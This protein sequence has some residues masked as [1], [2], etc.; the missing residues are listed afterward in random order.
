M[1]E[2]AIQNLPEKP[3][4]VLRANESRIGADLEELWKYREMFYFLTWRDVKV[5]YKQTALGAL[6]AL[7]QPL[8]LMLI[9]TLFISRMVG[10]QTQGLPY[11]LFAY[12]G[13]L[14]WTFF[15]NA[16]TNSGNSLISS[17]NL[18]TKVYFP[19]MIIPASSVAAGLVDFCVA[20]PLLI[21]LM[22]YYK[23]GVHLSMLMLPVLVALTTILAVGV[24]LLMSSLNVT[25]RD[26]RYALPFLVQMWMFS[27]PVFYPIPANWRRLLSLNPMTGIIDGFR[28]ALFGK[29]FD[30]FTLGLSTVITLL[31]LLASIVVFK[32]MEKTFADVI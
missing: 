31:V 32:R 17:T 21:V 12:A 25:Y 23:T 19:R 18:I 14:P 28:S 13:L 15:A 4:V 26:I 10:L 6:W 27:S 2:T 30:W 11:P 8:L 24:G 22:I 7:L 20:F 16:V 29:P 9:F 1:T 3:L 5:R